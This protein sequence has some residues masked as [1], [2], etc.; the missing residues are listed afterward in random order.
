MCTIG[1]SW[2]IFLTFNICKIKGYLLKPYIHT[3]CF[4]LIKRHWRL[5]IRR[6]VRKNKIIVQTYRTFLFNL[7]AYL[8]ESCTVVGCSVVST[9]TSLLVGAEQTEPECTDG[10]CTCD[11]NSDPLQRIFSGTTYKFC[12]S[13]NIFYH[14]LLC[15][16]QYSRYRG[17]Q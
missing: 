10:K 6:K 15:T 12:Q 8:G 17:S 7:L 11:S 14:L 3:A 5:M 2:R 9:V 1:F 16:F 13:I 4:L